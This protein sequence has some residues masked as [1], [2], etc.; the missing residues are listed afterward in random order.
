[1][2]GLVGIAAMI[3]AAFAIGGLWLFGIVEGVRWLAVTH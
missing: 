1:M 2:K 3:F